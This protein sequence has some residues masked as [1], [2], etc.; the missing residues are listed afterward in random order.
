LSTMIAKDHQSNEDTTIVIDIVSI[1]FIH[2][3]SIEMKF[4]SL[5]S[6]SSQIWRYNIDWLIIV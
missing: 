5:S 2:M 6:S 3:I 4:P 1:I